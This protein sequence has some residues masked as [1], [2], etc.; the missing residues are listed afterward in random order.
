MTVEGWAD[1]F[2]RINHRDAVIE[3]LDYCMKNKGLVIYGFCLMTNHLHLIVSCEKPFYLKD[4]IR[5]FKKFTSKKITRQI[6]EEP[7]SRREWLLSV[8]ANSGAGSRKHTHYRFWQEGNHAIEL[9]TEKFVW[10]K[11]N[12]IH[13]NPVRAKFVKAAED[14]VYSSASNY[15]G[16]ASIIEVE[17]LMPGLVTG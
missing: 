3:G 7:E 1:V 12:Y 10:E 14:W 2:S 13:Q 8:F 11:L 4:V 15:A 16:M 6:E 17:V 5:D 9:Y